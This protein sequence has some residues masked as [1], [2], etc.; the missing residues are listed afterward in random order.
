[1]I[2]S[3][4][5]IT[6]NGKRFVA[7]LY[8]Q[9]LQRP[10]A[11]LAEAREIGRRERMD[12]VAIRRG[13]VLQAG[14]ATQK[15]IGNGGA[16]S[17]AAALGG[18][19]GDDW[20][21]VFELDSSTYAIAAAKNGAIIPGCDAVGSRSEI[22][23]ILRTNYNLHQFARVIC[24]RDFGFGAEEELQL[25]DV[26]Q[27]SK[28]KKEY[29]LRPLSKGVRREIVVGGLALL[30]L[31]GAAVGFVLYKEHKKEEERIAAAAA[32]AA[33]AQRLADLEKAS[34]TKVAPIALTHPW[35]MQPIATE[36]IAACVAT[37]HD[38]PLSLGGWLFDSASCT[39][40]SVQAVFRREPGATVNGFLSRALEL[41]YQGATV[42]DAG[43]QANVAVPFVPVKPGGDDALLPHA[44]VADAVRSVLQSRQVTYSVVLKPPP[45]PPPP[46]PGEEAPPPPPAPDWKTSTLTSTSNVTPVDMLGGIERLPGLRVLTIAVRR[47]VS[48]LEWSLTGEINGN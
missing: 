37:L 36:F 19:F 20:I 30:L 22:D 39:D 28:L 1:M 47:D 29:R 4:E 38:L 14:F 6:V 34:G 40:A 24:P 7:G 33:E 31:V 9:T 17:F 26:L 21:A 3:A 8:W 18:V 43:E 27:P 48:T 46:L 11:Y 5:T 35:A 10:R 13:R 25:A 44:L 2:E 32:A 45:A 16:Y 42:D 12:I 15:T 41:N 23:E